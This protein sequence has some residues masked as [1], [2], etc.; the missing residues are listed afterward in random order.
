MPAGPTDKNLKRY[1]LRKAVGREATLQAWDAADE[2]LLEHAQSLSLD[3]ARVLILNDS[4]GALSCG[5][6]AA[7]PA[8][9]TTSATYTDSYISARAISLNSGGRISAI[10]RL[11]D[12][13]GPYDFVFGRIPKNLSFFE[14]E[15]CHLS[16]Q[17]SPGGRVAFGVMVKHQAKGA[18]DL[19]DRIIG[20]TTTSLARKKARLIFAELKREPIRSP[21]PRE[22]E[23]EGFAEPFVQTSNLFSREQLDIGTRFF[24]EH[25]PE[26]DFETILD[27]GCA[28]GIVGIRAKELN[29]ASGVVFVDESAMAIESA[30]ANYERRFG[31]KPVTVWTNCYEDQPAESLDLVLCNPPFHQGTSVGDHVAWQMFTDARHALNPGGLLRV[32]GNTHLRYPGALKKIFGNSEIVASNSKFTIVDAVKN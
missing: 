25:I 29:P 23:I 3:G 16:A 31:Q 21:Y 2:L 12:L 18:F 7:A 20:P 32:I 8:A 9:P 1:P 14:D 15:L 6:Q 24:L 19:L 22:V 11:S 17:L 28:N 10:H 26:G 13:Q 30:S 4:F 27:L 5:L